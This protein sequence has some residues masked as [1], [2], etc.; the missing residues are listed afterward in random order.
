MFE[1]II[2][3]EEVALEKMQYLQFQRNFISYRAASIPGHLV[4]LTDKK[5]A[6]PNGST[7]HTINHFLDYDPTMGI[8]PDLSNPFYLHEQWPVYFQHA[9]DSANGESHPF[10]VTDNYML[11]YGRARAQALQFFQEHKKIRRLISKTSVERQQNVLMWY[12]YAALEKIRVVG[13]FNDYRKFDIIFR[14]ILDNVMSSSNQR[15]HFIMLPMTGGTLNRAQM[16]MAFR[17]LDQTTMRVRND[18]S[19]FFLVHLLGLA[20]GAATPLNAVPWPSDMAMWKESQDPMS[21]EDYLALSEDDQDKYLN[22]MYPGFEGRVEMENRKAYVYPILRSTSL[23]DRIPSPMS[24]RINFVLTHG[25]KAVVYNLGDLQHFANTVP[26]FF[27]RLLRHVTMLKASQIS[28]KS[29]HELQE[30]SDDA[31]DRHIDTLANPVLDSMHVDDDS[32]LESDGLSIQEDEAVI[33]NAEKAH[34]DH[35]V[36]DSDTVEVQE[37]AAHPSKEMPIKPTPEQVKKDFAPLAQSYVQNVKDNLANRLATDERTTQASYK[38]AES[39]MEV[40]RNVRIGGKTIAEHLEHTPDRQISENHLGFLTNDV[41]DPSMLKSS[42]ADM[43]R[44]YMEHQY[45]RDI[46]KVLTSFVAHGMFVADVK[47]ETTVDRFNRLTHYRVKMIDTNG[48]QHTINFHLP[49]VDANGQMLTGGVITR[50]VKQQVNLPICKIAEDRVSLSSNYNK[51]IVKR[52]SRVANDFGSYI[53]RYLNSLRKLDLITVRYGSFITTTEKLPYEYSTIAKTFF[54]ISARGYEFVFDY[55]HRFKGLPEGISPTQVVEM[56]KTYGVFSG[57]SPNNSLLFWDMANAL[58]VV[59]VDGT[60]HSSSIHFME[61]MH[62]LFGKES[63]TPPMISQYTEMNLQGNKFPTMM[64]LCYQF[65]ITEVLK[66]IGLEYTFVPEGERPRVSI[67]DIRIPFADGSLVFSRYPLHKSLIASGLKWMN[68][69]AYTFKDLDVQDTYF[70]ICNDKRVSHN[71]LVGITEAFRLFIDPITYDVLV[72]MHEPTTFAGLIIRSTQ[73]LADNAHL[74]ASSLAHHRLRGYERTVSILYNEM[75]RQF[76]TYNKKRSA[77]GGYSINPRA[78]YERV[79]GD[80]SVVNSDVI[81]PIHEM[82]SQNNITFGGTGGRTSQ[83]FVVPDRQYPADAVGSISE[84]T[85]DSGKVAMTV[86][87]SVD[88]RL[89]NDRGMY[90]ANPNN[91]EAVTPAQM[92]SPVAM[93]M[94]GVTQDD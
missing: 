67:G 78:V 10:P 34:R 19:Y 62:G 50:M 13:R 24:D 20:Y 79:M 46:A 35:V 43:D 21:E 70:A 52:V 55:D 29:V 81:N 30:M 7:L 57:T 86:Y 60:H 28:D 45:N 90:D 16:L 77:V 32:N 26:N 41:P 47:E 31:F 63:E 65:G 5:V 25:D 42:I 53:V 51:A 69:R 64:V 12:D 14:S 76:A 59:S 48:K 49:T 72:H 1:K 88:P 8:D 2:R 71:F 3:R 44:S 40:H 93:L 9:F 92:L 87:A 54:G 68:T 58:H 61:L 80:S 74:P 4:D 84:A 66:M 27:A 89:A 85:P 37:D 36:E 56:E 23:L 15:H 91:S 17:R 75:A 18:P 6:L 82:K 38:R 83:S 39:L 11:T 33:A 73:M 94:P 22:S